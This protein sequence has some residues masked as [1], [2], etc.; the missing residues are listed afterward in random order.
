MQSEKKLA[1]LIGCGIQGSSS[2]QIHEAEATSLGS[3]LCTGSSIWNNRRG[4]LHILLNFSKQQN[5]QDSRT[6]V[7]AGPLPTSC[8]S[9]SFLR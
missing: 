7:M 1:G 5:R 2:P 3:I 8:C 4:S 6:W 9:R